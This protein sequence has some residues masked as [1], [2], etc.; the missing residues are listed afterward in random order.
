MA[1]P[2]VIALVALFAT[3][4]SAPQIRTGGTPEAFVAGH[5][6]L[7]LLTCD[8]GC[9]GE[10][11]HAAGRLFRIDPSSRRVAASTSLPRPG[12][13]AV[14]SR[15]VYALDFWRDRI[16]L[17]DPRT[18]QVVRSLRL[19]LPFRFTPH[20]SAFLPEAVAVGGDSVWVASD[21]GALDRAD[22]R[23]RRVRA[24]VRL[25]FDAFGG[26][27]A[28]PHAVWLGESLAGVYRIDPRQNRIV[29]RMRI[30][31][32]DATDPVRCGGEVLV[33][34]TWTS[35]GA[36]TNRSSLARVIGNR[37]TVVTE[38]PHGP[39]VLTCG[40]GSLWV[41]RQGGSTIE[42]IDPASGRIVERRSARVGVALAF[43]G[44]RLWTADQNGTVR[45][46]GR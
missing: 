6:S 8:R 23:V 2:I 3:A 5:G 41:G 14:G 22:L 29:A 24:T 10:A 33:Q 46:L 25:P 12:A 7:W 26:I 39:L 30:P 16:R 4:G 20:D 32:L 13:I 21:R 18:L 9:S 36:L 34:G 43:A 31:R 27:A 42:R 37:I 19:R 35:G 17:I 28:G 40:G 15:W 38:L 1:R 11:R 45:Q 44:G